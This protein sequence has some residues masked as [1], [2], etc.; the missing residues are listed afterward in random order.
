MSYPRRFFECEYN[1]AMNK[2]WLR[3]IWMAALLAVLLGSLSP[4]LAPPAFWELDKA[5][6]FSTFAALAAAVPFTAGRTSRRL[7]LLAILLGV[8][9]SIEILQSFV[10]GRS[11]SILDFGADFA[12]LAVGALAGLWLSRHLPAFIGAR[13]MTSG[14]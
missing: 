7:L 2:L 4:A 9:A 12:G 14:D 3:A 13:F 10:P 11:A 1:F 8:G 6:H 5:L